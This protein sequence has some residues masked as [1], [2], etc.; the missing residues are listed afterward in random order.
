MKLYTECFWKD[1]DRIVDIFIE[2]TDAIPEYIND[3]STYKIITLGKG[4]VQMESNN[5]TYD[6]KAPALILLSQNDK[7]RFHIAGEIEAGL[8]FFKPTAVR[9]EFTY[10][11]IAAGEFRD[12]VGRTIQQDY[13]LIRQFEPETKL[14]ERIIPLS[15]NSLKRMTDLLYAAA[16]EL[17]GQRDG[18]WPCRSRSYLMEILYFINY[19]YSEMDP[20]TAFNIESSEDAV[21]SKVIEYL[22]E[23][24]D[25]KITLAMLTKEFNMN[26]NKLND[27]FM[28]K[29]S[30]TCLDYLLILRIDLAKIMLTKTEL[31]IGEI[32]ARV[33]YP[34]T[35]YFAKIFK[36]CTGMTPSQYRKS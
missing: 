9:E 6:I 22:N 19:T 35:N 26:R 4:A 23:H 13:L 3:D 12:L 15:L 34:D 28:Q 25:E 24:I 1:W 17:L 18:F 14:N 7:V 21:Y 2:K 11:R 27:L 20:Q 36:N 33:G 31:P 10:E 30:M 29:T 32:S 8:L 5:V 16:R